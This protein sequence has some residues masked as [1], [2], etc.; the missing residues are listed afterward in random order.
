MG[1]LNFT[2]LEY[3]Q[4]RKKTRREILL[5]EMDE[6][7][8]WDAWEELV[9]PFYPAGSR[10]RKPQSIKRMLKMFMLKTWFNLS[11]LATE[12]AVYDSYSMKQ[13]LDI[14]FSQNDQ[15]PD[16]TTLCKFRNLLKKNNLEKEI[17]SQF[18]QI[19]KG[20]GKQ[21]RNGVLINR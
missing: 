5:E 7:L 8:P 14:D 16:S 11:D 10:G 2:D 21:I 20:N 1:Q 3:M 19:L 15:V 13:F 9:K 6:L 4:R 18:R 17:L 12:E